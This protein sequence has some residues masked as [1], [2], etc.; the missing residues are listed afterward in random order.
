M[1]GSVVRMSAISEPSTEPMI[2]PST[3]DRAMRRGRRG[4]PRRTDWRLGGRTVRRWREMLVAWS[5][6]SLGVGVTAGYGIQTLWPTASWAPLASTLVLWGS[7][8]APVVY[9][10]A[11]SRPI[12][13]LRLRPVDLLFGLALGVFLRLFQGWVAQ[14]S[15]AGAV[16]PSYI[17]L[18]GTLPTTW[19]LSDAIP[20]AI[21]APVIEE[22]FFRAVILVALYTALRRGFGHLTAGLA[23]FLVSTALFI[24]VHSINGA[25]TTDAV[26]AIGALG[27]TCALLVLLTGRI[28]PA[29][30]VHIV[31]NTTGLILG[32]VG[33]FAG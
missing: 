24:V 25:I 28:W 23:A 16:F 33:T 32:L 6:L 22:F 7:M 18:D 30:L 2:E 27:A 15:G 5:L 1:L 3:D 11:R 13:L 31:Y 12:G 9:A 21:V 14:M 4:R 19:W 17:T 10:F 26:V 29:V 8:L 20:A